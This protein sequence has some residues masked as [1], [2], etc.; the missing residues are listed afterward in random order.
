MP[1]SKVNS[2][3]LPCLVDKKVGSLDFALAE[4]VVMYFDNTMST[5]V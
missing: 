5:R 1:A 3:M 2:H 4:E